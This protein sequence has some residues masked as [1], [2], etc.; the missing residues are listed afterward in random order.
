MDLY[1]ARSSR[2]H[3]VFDVYI[4][5]LNT[6]DPATEEELGTVPEMG[7]TE[8]KQAIDAASQAFKSWSKTTA[9]A[10]PCPNLPICEI[11]TQ[12]VGSNDMIS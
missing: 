7:L 5:A 8:T 4:N 3:S 2:V 10:C 9:K 6:S 1:T 12:R 11:L